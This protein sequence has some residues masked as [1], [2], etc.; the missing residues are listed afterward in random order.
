MVDIGRLG[1][2]LQDVISQILS[3][4]FLKN[5]K[6]LKTFSIADIAMHW[7]AGDHAALAPV[8]SDVQASQIPAAYLEDTEDVAAAKV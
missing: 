2:F 4:V 3:F 8:N 1:Q 6:I 7:Q 5:P